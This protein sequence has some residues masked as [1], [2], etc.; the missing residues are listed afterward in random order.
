MTWPLCCGKRKKKAKAFFLCIPVRY[1]QLFF[2]FGTGK[3]AQIAGCRGGQTM[4]MKIAVIGGDGIGPEIVAE[5]R[6]VLDVSVR[7]TGI[8]FITRIF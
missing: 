2:G 6:K 8:P 7:S 3:S 5:A 4:E 1:L